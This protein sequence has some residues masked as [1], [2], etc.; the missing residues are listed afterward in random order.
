[1]STSPTN[2]HLL[3]LRNAISAAFSLEELRGLCFELGIDFDDIRGETREAKA[4]E[5]VLYC[6]RRSRLEQLAEACARLRPNISW[7]GAVPMRTIL[8]LAAEPS[9]APQ[10][11]LGRE[12]RQVQEVLRTGRLAPRYTLEHRPALRPQDLTQALHDT[13]PAIVH[14]AGHATGA[15]ELSLEDDT[16]QVHVVSPQ[17]LADLF[18]LAAGYLECVVLNACYAAAQAQAIARHIPYVIG[19]EKAIT[20]EASQA[21]S[22]GFYKALAAGEA[23]PAAFEFG[24]IEIELRNLPYPPNPILLRKGE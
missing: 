6:Q 1:M 16:G 13:H 22:A 2:S 3:G 19:M 11:R 21:F 14:F 17:V 24:R 5:L 4:R 7:P 23:I 12:L 9:D 18:A 15:G 10:L 20:D 8:F